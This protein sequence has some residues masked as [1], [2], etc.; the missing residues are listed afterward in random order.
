MPHI[1]TEPN[2]HDV[3]VSAWLFRGDEQQE[4]FVH[5]HRKIRK[6]MQIG[7][8]IELDETPWQAIA[9]EI[10]EEAGYKLNNLEIYQPDYMPVEL[11]DVVVHPVPSLVVTYQPVP[12][13]YHTD[14]AYV[15]HEISKPSGAPDANESNDFRWMT[16]DE[17]L[18]GKEAGEVLSDVAETYV[19]LR[20]IIGSNGYKQLPASL[21]SLAKPP[22]NEEAMEKTVL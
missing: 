1:H 22:L 12:G 21:F 4:V 16:F 8:H 2:Q 13:H 11:S 9:H 6:Y 19:K 5:M 7:G 18:S 3:T 15:F 10:A 14:F 20:G 17:L